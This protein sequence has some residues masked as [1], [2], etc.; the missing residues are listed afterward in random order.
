MYILDQYCLCY[1]WR[2]FFFCA[3]FLIGSEQRSS[4]LATPDQ[5]L[6]GF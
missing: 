6:S 1:Y 2:E 4:D 3:Y 5:H